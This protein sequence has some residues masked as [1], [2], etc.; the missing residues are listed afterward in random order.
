MYLLTRIAELAL[1]SLLAFSLALL[2]GRITL[3]AVFRLAFCRLRAREQQPL[4]HLAHTG[5]ISAA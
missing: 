2:V 3:T 4:P 1:A 5:R